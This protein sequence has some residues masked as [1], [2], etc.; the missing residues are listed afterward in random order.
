MEPLYILILAIVGLFTASLT[1][2]KIISM[3]KETPAGNNGG[4][5]KA[6]VVSIEALIA[7]K[8]DKVLCD[9][10]HAHVLRD[11]A[12]GQEQFEA[13]LKVQSHQADM[14]SRID[15]RVEYLAERDGFGKGRKR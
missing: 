14:L 8:R 6:K 2:L 15:E 13:I 12:K 4:N 5:L 3:R 9:E 7:Q 1:I 10:R 11:L